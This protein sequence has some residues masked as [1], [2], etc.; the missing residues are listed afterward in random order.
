MAGCVEN[1]GAG[2]LSFL[3]P[4]P[5]SC[6]GARR[7][8]ACFVRLTLAF[9]GAPFIRHESDC[10]HFL[11]SQ[12]R[13]HWKVH[14]AKKTQHHKQTVNYL[15]RYLK[16]PPVAASRLRHYS[17]GGQVTFTFLNHRTQKK[18]SMV[19][20][21]LEMI[22]RLVEHIPEKHFKMLR[23]D[24]FLSNRKRGEMLPRV[25][26]ALKQAPPEVP[27]A[28]G[29]AA[30]LKGYV[31]VDPYACVLCTG[32]MVYTGFRSGSTVGELISQ[33]KLQASR[34]PV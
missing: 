31:N 4:N 7:L 11:D 18:E 32:R 10:S 9:D 15:G 8:S 29:Y 1:R 14:F 24:G 3:K 25:Y 2:T 23:Y 30:M 27:E 13:R 5:Q 19:L 16:R 34:R 26:A 21:P 6:A 12:Y 33:T 20:T 22:G 17:R 28:P